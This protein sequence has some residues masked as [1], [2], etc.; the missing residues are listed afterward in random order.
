ML[1][2]VRLR[3]GVRLRRRGS[4]EGPDVQI[5][6]PLR[7]AGRGSARNAAIAKI[8]FLAGSADARGGVVCGPEASTLRDLPGNAHI[9]LG[10][11]YIEALANLGKVGDFDAGDR[12]DARDW[13]NAGEIAQQGVEDG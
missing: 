2:N 6:V 11:A 3:K 13:W 12:W 8:A 5:Q 10:A 1:I 7:R 9:H 4:G